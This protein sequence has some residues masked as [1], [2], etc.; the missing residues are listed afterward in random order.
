MGILDRIILFGGSGFI[1]THLL[2][3]L[4]EN[5]HTVLNFDIN[6]PFDKPHLKFFHF[7]DV[8]Q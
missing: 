6:N 5:E 3:R 1:G 4:V 7:G 8:M 2:N